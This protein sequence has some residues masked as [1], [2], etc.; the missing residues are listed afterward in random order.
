[1]RWGPG[2]SGCGGVGRVLFDPHGG[3]WGLVASV[4]FKTAVT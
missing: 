4:V 2:T 3:G 1:M